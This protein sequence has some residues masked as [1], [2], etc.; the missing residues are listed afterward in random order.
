MVPQELRYSLNAFERTRTNGQLVLQFRPIK[1][2]TATLDHTY[3]ENKIHSKRAELSAWFNFGPSSSSWTNG[4]IATPTNYTET[5]PASRPRRCGHGRQ[6]LRHQEQEPVH[7]CEP[8]L[9]G[10]E[11]AV[12]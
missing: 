9:E 11:R 6:H 10:L 2:L 3:S 4:P 8:G 5:Y 12:L 7:R 1:D